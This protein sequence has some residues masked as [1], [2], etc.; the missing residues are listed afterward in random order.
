MAPDNNDRH[1]YDADTRQ[2]AMFGNLIVSSIESSLVNAGA[3]L[4]II[5]LVLLILPMLY[6]LRSTNIARELAQR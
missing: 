4:V 2:T 6:Y 5:L 3:A 1:S